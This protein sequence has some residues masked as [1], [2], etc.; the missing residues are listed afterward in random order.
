MHYNEI[1]EESPVE[2]PVTESPRGARDLYRPDFSD[3]DDDPGIY[4][5]GPP[6]GINMKMS[7]YMYLLFVTFDL[8]FLLLFH[9]LLM[10]VPLVIHAIFLPVVI[11]LVIKQKKFGNHPDLMRDFIK[12][13]LRYML[14]YIITRIVVAVIMLD[15]FSLLFL[16]YIGVKVVMTWIQMSRLMNLARD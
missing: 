4:V 3:E 7:L 11:A 16:G 12:V 13:N 5:S 6:I 8:V 15:F 10:A 9:Q 14:V 2:N 1:Y